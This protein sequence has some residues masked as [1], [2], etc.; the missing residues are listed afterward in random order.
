MI[1]PSG[2][3]VVPAASSK[4]PLAST[5][6][7]ESYGCLSSALADHRAT[8]PYVGNKST[9]RS[10]ARTAPAYQTPI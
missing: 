9:L 6:R 10:L 7:V 2:I 4:A 8:Q 5:R 3:T 1:Q